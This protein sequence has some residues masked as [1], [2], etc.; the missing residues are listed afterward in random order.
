MS[1]HSPEALIVIKFLQDNAETLSLISDIWSI[2]GIPTGIFTLVAAYLQARKARK[3]SELAAAEVNTFRNQIRYFNSISDLT[4]ALSGIDELRRL[5]RHKV[6]TALPDRLSEI[7]HALIAVRESADNLTEKDQKTFQSMIVEL[8][9][10]ES[11]WSENIED[12]K[13]STKI[14]VTIGK[15]LRKTDALHETLNTMRTKLGNDND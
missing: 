10:L 13:L 7:R 9:G 14:S 4:K 5:I 12:G 6:Y 11:I 1:T 8:R 15:I 3:A 2:I